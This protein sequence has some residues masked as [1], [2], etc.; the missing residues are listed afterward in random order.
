MNLG[1]IH[2]LKI[3]E[4]YFT[5]ILYRSKRFE[6]RF[7]DRH[8]KCGDV[9]ELKEWTGTKFTGRIIAARV[10]YVS[11]AMQREGYVCM[12][13]DQIRQHFLTC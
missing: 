3:Q 7:N 4:Q 6:T 1:N 9:L 2:V 8:Y 10:T 13:I 11:S 12:S 5:D